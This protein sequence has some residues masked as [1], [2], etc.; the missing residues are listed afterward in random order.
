M[1][2]PTSR[3]QCYAKV[4]IRWRI[5]IVIAHCYR[6]PMLTTH[7]TPALIHRVTMIVGVAVLGLSVL[8]T[9]PAQAREEWCGVVIAP[10]ER[11]ATS[12]EGVTCRKGQ[13][14][15]SKARAQVRNDRGKT[16]VGEFRCRVNT[17]GSGTSG[18][19]QNGP[20]RVMWSTSRLP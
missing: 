5:S 1:T 9:T 7:K 6:A 14:V 16:S 8:T 18:I 2:T 11:I 19:C 4:D 3:C 15:L 20:K 13:R 17:H 12:V 10:N